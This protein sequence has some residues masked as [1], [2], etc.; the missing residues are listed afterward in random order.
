VDVEVG[1]WLEHARWLRDPRKP[2]EFPLDGRGTLEVHHV[3]GSLAAAK[4]RLRCDLDGGRIAR[5]HRDHCCAH[6]RPVGR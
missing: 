4:Q 5:E 3:N 2:I 6:A 1:P